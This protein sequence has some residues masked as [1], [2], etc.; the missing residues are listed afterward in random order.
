[1]TAYLIRY[2]LGD[3]KD[4]H[5][6]WRWS[7][8]LLN[9]PLLPPIITYII[10]ISRTKGS[11]E[12]TVDSQRKLDP[13]LIIMSEVM[14]YDLGSEE[15]RVVTKASLFPIANYEQV[16]RVHTRA[17]TSTSFRLIDIGCNKNFMAV[18]LSQKL[19]RT[20][21]YLATL[22]WGDNIP[23]N[24][25]KDRWFWVGPI[26]TCTDTLCF[27]AGLC[28]QTDPRAQMS[29]EKSRYDVTLMRPNNLANPTDSNEL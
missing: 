12:S 14:Y 10:F 21:R 4:R 13:F 24:L 15:L 8:S 20:N 26:D 11:L 5:A 6:L 28:Q 3:T 16:E 22:H 1:M 29:G 23:P 2:Q 7:L 9:L 27:H 17:C 18:P 25:K 19:E